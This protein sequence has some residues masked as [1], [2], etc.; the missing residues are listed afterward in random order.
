MRPISISYAPSV[1]SANAIA[2]SQTPGAAGAVTL[3]GS[4]VTG[5]V[6]T[7]GGQQ[8]VTITSTSDISNRTFA[9]T[10]TDRN[11]NAISETLT[12]PNNATVASLKNYY[13]LTS[14]V[15]SGSAAG[16]ITLGVN[17]LGESRPYPVDIYQGPFQVAV[18][19]TAVVGATYKMSYTYDDIQ[20]PAWPN[21]TQTWFDS[22]LMVGKTTTSD[23]VINGGPVTAIR[24]A[25]TTAGSPQ[26]LTARIIQ[27]GMD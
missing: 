16:A 2:L 26:S 18:A 25:I 23:T 4:L 9:L 11:G 6:A 10:G 5:G 19:V 12:G 1:S 24:F 27:A 7:M 13:T 22:Q 3:N 15:I 8:H 17:G 14:A 21:G 20:D